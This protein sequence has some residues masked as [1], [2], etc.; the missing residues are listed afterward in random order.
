MMTMEA[1]TPEPEALSLDGALALVRRG[2]RGGFTQLVN[3]LQPRVY[4]WAL[5]IASDPD[6]ADEISQE[7]FVM[8]HRNL[9]QFKGDAP[10]EGWVYGIVRRIANQRKRRRGRRARLAES[11]GWT[12]TIVADVY[13]TDPGARVDRERLA[14]FV[15]HYFSGLPPRQREVFDLVDLQ[16]YDPSEAAVLLNIKQGTV[17]AN[18]FKARAAIRAHILAAHP[19]WGDLR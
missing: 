14:A 19:A 18:L 4:R 12:R 16:G 17:R 10:L 13:T 2:H 6:E 3:I 7:A 1:A 11:A 9:H 8:V 15:N 5:G